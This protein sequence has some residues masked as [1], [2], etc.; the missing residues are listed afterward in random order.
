MQSWVDEED[1]GGVGRGEKHDHNVL[2]EKIILN[3]NLR[4]VLEKK[5]KTVN[6]EDS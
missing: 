3:K 5:M 6:I 1:L 4:N 2:H